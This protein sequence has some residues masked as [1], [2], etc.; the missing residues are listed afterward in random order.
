MHQIHENIKDILPFI[1]II[2]YSSNE[3]VGIIINQD[4]YVTSFYDLSSI[5]SPE[6]KARI[7]ELGDIWWWETN[8]KI[9]INIF[10]NKEMSIF[11]YAIKTFTTKDVKLVFGP[12]VC[13]STVSDRRLRRRSVHLIRPPKK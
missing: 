5:K 1:S 4:S 8:H 13:L 3:Y 2:H 9:P 6:E 12:V 11:Q 10:L 7:L